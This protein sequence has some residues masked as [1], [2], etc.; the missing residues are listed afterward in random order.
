MPDNTTIE[1]N[2]SIFSLS[3]MHK[4]QRERAY[5]QKNVAPTKSCNY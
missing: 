1:E 4:L 5:R 3:L 2:Y